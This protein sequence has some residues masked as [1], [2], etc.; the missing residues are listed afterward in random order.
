MKIHDGDFPEEKE[1][2]AKLVRLAR[3]LNAKLFT[4]DYNLGKIAELQNV[5]CVNLHEVAKCL[6]VILLP[7]E[8]LQLA[9]RPRRQG[10]GPGRRLSARRHDGRRQQ[11]PHRTSASRSRS[12]VQSLLQTGAGV[13][14]FADMRG[15]SA[16]TETNFITR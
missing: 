1:V 5:N 12:Q 7:G 16:K 6:K 11:R 8:M 3:N 10:Q 4:N 15:P 14:V 2:D 9:N 13:I